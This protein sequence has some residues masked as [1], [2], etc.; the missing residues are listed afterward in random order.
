MHVP[1]KGLTL[2]CSTEGRGRRHGALNVLA[3]LITDAEVGFPAEQ[4]G[5]AT[6]VALPG[7]SFVAEGDTLG[8]SDNCSGDGDCNGN[9]CGGVAEGHC[10]L[11]LAATGGASFALSCSGLTNG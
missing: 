10:G 4:A 9:V 1:S 8:G 3:S 7:P 2:A 6:D 5:E 11:A